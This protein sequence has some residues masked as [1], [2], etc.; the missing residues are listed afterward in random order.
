MVFFRVFLGLFFIAQLLAMILIDPIIDKV[1]VMQSNTTIKQAPYKDF[2][3]LRR[4]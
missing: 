4:L 2:S 3:D 1:S